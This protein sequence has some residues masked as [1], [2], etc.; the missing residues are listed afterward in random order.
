MP[1]PFQI[2]TTSDGRT[3]A[4]GQ[5]L[6]YGMQPLT[7]AAAEASIS[8]IYRA[9]AGTMPSGTPA[10]VSFKSVER[11]PP[12]DCSVPPEPAAAAGGWNT[13]NTCA[14]LRSHDPFVGDPCVGMFSNPNLPAQTCLYRETRVEVGGIDGPGNSWSLSPI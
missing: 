3:M 1:V 9:I 12:R 7:E 8:P 4:I 14:T 13:A 10:I 5:A 2:N 11:A 6:V